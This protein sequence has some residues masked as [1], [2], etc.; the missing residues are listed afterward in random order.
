MVNFLPDSILTIVTSSILPLQIVPHLNTN[1]LRVRSLYFTD[2]TLSFSLQFVFSPLQH[3]QHPHVMS[4][5]L[6]SQFF[7]KDLFYL[8]NNQD[9]FEKYPITGVQ[10]TKDDIGKFILVQ[11][12][13]KKRKQQ[14]NIL[15]NCSLILTSSKSSSV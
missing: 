11:I 5:K 7:F 1:S 12:M 13:K 2:Q 4:T 3:V 8:I 15:I 14:T 6:L 10:M 9:L